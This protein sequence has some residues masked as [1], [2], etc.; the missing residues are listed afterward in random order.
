MSLLNALTLGSMP[1]TGEFVLRTEDIEFGS[2]WWFVYA[3]V[4]CFLV[5]F[6]GIMSGL[7]LGLM[8]LGLVELEILQRSGTSAEKKQ[9]GRYNSIP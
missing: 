4:S 1:T 2:L 5:L 8:S 7:T 3:G 9:A 6:A